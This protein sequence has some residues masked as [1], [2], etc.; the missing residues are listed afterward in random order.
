MAQTLSKE[1][2]SGKNFELCHLITPILS[3]L[4]PQNKYLH[5]N[6]YTKAAHEITDF[7]T[8]Q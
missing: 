8:T 4:W 3:C 7:S 5:Q 2:C 6:T 1:I